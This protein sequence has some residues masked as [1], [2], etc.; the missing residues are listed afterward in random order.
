MM[1]AVMAGTRL[2]GRDHEA[3]VIARLVTGV[4]QGGQVLVI[5]GEAGIGKSALLT[6]AAT[7]A[8]AHGMLVLSTTGVQSEANLPFA[9][10]HQLLRPVLARYDGPAAG[11]GRG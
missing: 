7:I 4:H 9:G 1:N 5:R 11:P 8:A 10:L 2:V 3:G 6:Q